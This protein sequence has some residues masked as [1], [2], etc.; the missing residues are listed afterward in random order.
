MRA[1]FP[2]ASSSPAR[3]RSDCRSGRSARSS[4]RAAATTTRRRRLPP[5]LH[6]P[7]RRPSRRPG[8]RARPHQRRGR[9]VPPTRSRSRRPSSSRERRSTSPGSAGLQANDPKLVWGPEWE[10]L[11]GIKINVVELDYPDLF[12]KGLQE[13][14]AGSGAHDILTITPA[15][16][17]RLRRGRRDRSDRRMDGR[18]PQPGR[19]RGLPPPV[20][21]HVDPRRAELGLLRRRRYVRPLLPQGHLRGDGSATAHD[22]RRVDRDRAADHGR[23]GARGVRRRLLA[24]PVDP[25]MV[26]PAAVPGPGRRVFRSR[27]PGAADQQRDRRPHDGADSRGERDGGPR[28]RAARR[29]AGAHVLAA[30]QHRV[31]VLVAASRPV[32]GRVRRRRRGGVRLRRRVDRRGQGWVRQHPGRRLARRRL[33]LLLSQRTRRTRRPPT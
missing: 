30:G 15:M 14:I 27:E 16:A 17:R 9:A 21:G 2:V 11:T 22:L 1:D 25:A 29:R 26:V 18:V 13:H 28:R 7:S 4:R 19:P 3:R 12:T 10:E 32:V 33:R 5:S 24:E 6:R 8:R 31:D 23:E 20:Q